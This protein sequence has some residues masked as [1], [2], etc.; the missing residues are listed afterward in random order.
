MVNRRLG[1]V[2]PGT[3]STATEWS[4]LISQANP[5]VS[6]KSKSMPQPLVPKKL[7]LTSSM[8]THKTF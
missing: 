7:E 3:V 5:S 8:K 1:D 6:Q 4:R 2:A